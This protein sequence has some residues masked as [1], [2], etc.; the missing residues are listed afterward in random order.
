MFA[1]FI[2]YDSIMVSPIWASSVL[3]RMFR[4]YSLVCS[5]QEHRYKG[6]RWVKRFAISIVLLFI[7]SAT[8]LKYRWIKGTSV[9]KRFET[10]VVLHLI[11]ST[12]LFK[13]YHKTQ[14]SMRRLVINKVIYDPL[15]LHIYAELR[16]D[17]PFTLW[18]SQIVVSWQIR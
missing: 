6:Y 12:S 10:S 2:L 3:Y 17:K 9:G 11:L 7:L 1:I 15:F 18:K 4:L 14:Y 16:G 5:L 8:H 13:I